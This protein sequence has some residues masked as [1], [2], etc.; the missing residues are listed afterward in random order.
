MKNNKKILLI[1][2]GGIAAYKTL[3][4]IRNLRSKNYEIKTILTKTAEEFVTPLSISSLSNNKVYLNK[5]DLNEEIEMDHIALSRWADLI[6]VAPATA[7]IIENISNGSANDFINTV[8]LA[9]NKKIFLAP[10]MNVKMWEKDATQINVDKLKKRNF[11]MIGPSE[12]LL[13]C[14]EFGEGRMANVNE[15]EFTID[16]FF[17][18][19]D[20]NLSAVVTAGPTREYIDPVRYISNESS[21][22][23]GYY[24]A[25]KMVECGIKTKLIMGPSQIKIEDNINTIKVTTAQEMLEAVKESLPT[26]IAVCSAAVSDFRTDKF[27]QKIKK[28]NKDLNL[29][30]YQNMDILS[31]ISN[32]NNLR[33]KLVVGFAA[34]TNNVIEYAKKKLEQKHCD[35][36]IANDVSDKNIGF[37][38]KNNEI[39]IIRKNQEIE[40]I[41]KREKSE[42][43]TLLVQKILKEFPI[44]ENKS[45]N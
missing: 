8:I 41:S 16:N 27:E 7:N 32:H 43:A 12:G 36:I 21:G 26:D 17:I 4:L 25:K 6:L 15:I 1:I 19:K 45:L 31:F 20:I 42:I 40:K 18:K 28:N 2:S 9:S 11:S 35:W 14:G 34:E 24:I 3:D 23:Q 29:K 39:S 33:P 10:A 37:N 44:N 22:L 5:F 30:L 13:A 38:S